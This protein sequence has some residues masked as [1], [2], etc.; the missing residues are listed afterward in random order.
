M[1]PPAP[2]KN[3]RKEG[4]GFGLF[5]VVILFFFFFAVNGF[6][7]VIFNSLCEVTGHL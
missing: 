2:L 1:R 6:F 4:I 3:R 5:L 7:G